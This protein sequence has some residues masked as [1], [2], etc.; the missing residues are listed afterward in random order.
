M[1]NMIMNY[2]GGNRKNMAAFEDYFYDFCD[3]STKIQELN[4]KPDLLKSPVGKNFRAI[5]E[6]TILKTI[7]EALKTYHIDYSITVKE[8]HLEIKEVCGKLV[9]IATCVVRLDFFVEGYKEPIAFCEAIGMGIDDGD[10]AAGKAYT[11]AV[12][13]ALLKKFRICYS[14]DP[15]ATESHTIETAPEREEKGSKKGGNKKPKEE[16]P[17]ITEKMSGYIIGLVKKLDISDENFKKKYGY[18]PSSD[19]IPME[20]A[21][22]IIDELKA[23]EDDLPF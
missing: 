17:L 9:F 19:K 20:L 2:S 10:K 5:S 1:A 14:D 3:F 23:Q 12:K 21:R 7:N 11:Y 4:F 8:N 18:Y 16:G 13:Y 15:D 6:A 22:K